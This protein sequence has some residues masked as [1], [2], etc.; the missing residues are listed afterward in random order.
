MMFLDSFPDFFGRKERALCRI[1]RQP[2]P[3]GAGVYCSPQSRIATVDR[4]DIL[5]CTKPYVH[6]TKPLD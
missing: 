2:K 6:D 3:M 4:I 1:A 5:Q